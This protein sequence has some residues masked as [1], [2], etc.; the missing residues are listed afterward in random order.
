M[1]RESGIRVEVCINDQDGTFT[2]HTTN[3]DLGV[4]G[5]CRDVELADVDGDGD[6]DCIVARGANTANRDELLFL[7]EG[8]G[9]FSDEPIVLPNGGNNTINLEFGDLDN[10]GDIDLLPAHTSSANTFIL[11]DGTGNFQAFVPTP[12]WA[13]SRHVFAADMNG[14]GI[15]DVVAATQNSRLQVYLAD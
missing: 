5:I 3:S 9:F 8:D 7:N 12:G 2:P 13:N 15:L 1:A 11:N 10:D 6:L 14:D 4:A